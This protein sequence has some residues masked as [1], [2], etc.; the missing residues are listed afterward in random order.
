MSGS[1]SGCT[2][3]ELAVE[4][5]FVDI[6][7][8][9][10]DQVRHRRAA[11]FLAGTVADDRERRVVVRQRLRDTLTRD[12]I[13]QFSASRDLEEFVNQTEHELGMKGVIRAAEMEELKQTYE[14]RS[15][16][17]EIARRHLLE[18]LELEHRLEVLRREQTLDSTQ[19]QHR[20]DQE[21]KALEAGQQAEWTAYQQQLRRRQTDSEEAV[22]D[23]RAWSDSATIKM[24]VAGDA[25]ELRRKRAAQEH[26]QEKQRTELDE[27]RKDG[28][29]RR[30][31]DR[32]HALSE[33]E[34][35]RLAA[36]L[37]KTE[38]MK[39]L[40][41]DQILAM[42]AKDSPQVVAAISERARA[43]AQ[44][45]TAAGA[46]I[47]AL[48]EK[49]LAG[50]DAESNRLERVME[51]ALLSVERVAAGA[52]GRERDQKDEIKSVV[53]QGMDRMADVAVA[54]AGSP[55]GEGSAAGQVVCPQCRKLVPAG[56][57][58]CDECGHRF[59]D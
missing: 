53:G 2:G 37:K 5:R 8:P 10:Y 17:A 23:T 39:D 33:A 35:G 14:Q 34:Q 7:S 22:Q 44:A 6:A 16:D 50:K 45:G 3:L 24:A 57:K 51:R 54:R 21:R 46:E 31:L 4:L 26:E 52:A 18:K 27:W 32:I 48:Y 55:S 29:V 56:C 19:L 49:L 38:L 20:L 58:F 42:M 15:G 1:R 28:E 11:T 40:S 41:P 9:E 36:D 47:Q 43:Q 13:A 30:E 25:V 59:F 12:R